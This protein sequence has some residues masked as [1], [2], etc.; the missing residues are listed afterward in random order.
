MPEASTG[1]FGL[2]GKVVP[3]PSEEAWRLV[4]RSA[5]GHWLQTS[6][7]ETSLC[8]PSSH[9]KH[10]LSTSMSNPHVKLGRK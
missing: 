5:G 1:T 9:S 7:E 6:K 8:A 3:A 2:P 4:C 10:K